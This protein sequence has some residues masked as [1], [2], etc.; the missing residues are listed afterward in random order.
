LQRGELIQ[1]LQNRLRVGFS[2]ELHHHANAA[3]I[4]LIPQIGDAADAV[5]VG[6]LGHFFDPGG[7]VHLIG[8]LADDQGGSAVASFARLDLLEA[9][10]PPQG[11]GTAPGEVGCADPLGV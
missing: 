6:Q 7:F 5:L 3:A 2:L 4:R 10:Y 1:L 11:D 8:K 9:G